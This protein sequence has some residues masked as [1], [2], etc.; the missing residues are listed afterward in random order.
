MRPI[1]VLH[2]WI[3]EGLT[4][5]EYEFQGVEF[6]HVYR[7]SPG[8]FES[9]SLSREHVSRKMGRTLE[10]HTHTRHR[11]IIN[12]QNNDNNNNNTN[13]NDNIIIIISYSIIPITITITITIMNATTITIINR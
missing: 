1:S 11:Y 3:S 5:A 13:N 2:F 7:E 6:S 4:Q 8:R 10:A 12:N 9:R